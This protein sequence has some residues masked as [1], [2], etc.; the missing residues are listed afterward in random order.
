MR[1]AVENDPHVLGR[2]GERWRH[3]EHM[4]MVAVQQDGEALQH[5]SLRLRD[6][7]SVVSAAV[8]QKGW[9]LFRWASERLQ[10]NTRLIE[11]AKLHGVDDQSGIN[12]VEVYLKFPV[13]RRPGDPAAAGNDAKRARN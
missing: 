12:F 7:E 1:L 13:E 5:A 6:T 2:V 10:E 11:L 3:D 8:R 9:C 4:V